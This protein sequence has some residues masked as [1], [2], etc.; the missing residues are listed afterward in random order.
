VSPAGWHR[1]SRLPAVSEVPTVPAVS[2]LPAVSEVCAYDCSAC[3]LCACGCSSTLHPAHVH[4]ICFK[5]IQG[6][7]HSFQCHLTSPVTSFSYLCS[8][9]DLILHLSALLV[10]RHN[11]TQCIASRFK[12]A[13]LGW[14]V[15]ITTPMQPQP[16]RH[17]GWTTWAK[18]LGNMFVW[19]RLIPQCAS[20]GKGTAAFV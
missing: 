15:Q 10:H 14:N 11:S 5:C 6:F 20:R 19:L 4:T 13:V 9:G 1:V 17:H 8:V 3:S 18:R 7:K 2:E 16:H 12:A